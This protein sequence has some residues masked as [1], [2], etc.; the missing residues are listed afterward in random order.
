MVL[1]KERIIPPEPSDLVLAIT[2]GAVQRKWRTPT[3]F[4]ACPQGAHRQPILAY[5]ANLKP[6]VVFSRNAYS[7]HTVSKAAVSDNSSMLYVMS[8]S[9]G[10]KPWAFAKVTFEDGLYVHENCGSYFTKGGAE[11]QFCLAR[12]LEWAGGDSIDDYC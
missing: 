8:Q 10:M 3:E 1:A 2:L 12:G 6:G 4:P 9:D 7:T 5:A 11:K